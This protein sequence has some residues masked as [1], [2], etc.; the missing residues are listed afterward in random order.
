MGDPWTLIGWGVIAF[1][2]G[3]VL[4][5]VAVPLLSGEIAYLRWKRKVRQ[6][7]DRPFAKDQAWYA[8]KDPIPY[9]VTN[10]W[11][12]GTLNWSNEVRA[13]TRIGIKKSQVSWGWDE[14]VFREKVR[15]LKL[16]LKE[17]S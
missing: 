8:Y 16:H 13:V 15:S 11:E 12:E 5:Q 4:V 7:R 9:R 1:A 6:T 10:V 14:P 2:I 3:W 17:V